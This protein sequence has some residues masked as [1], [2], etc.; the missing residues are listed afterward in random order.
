M[1]DQENKPITRGTERDGGVEGATAD[2]AH[3]RDADENREA[4]RQPVK[5]VLRV[6]L[7]RRRVQ[8]HIGERELA[9]GSR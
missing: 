7:A 8:H 6:I 9:A 1:F 3:R 4:D 2:P 5:R